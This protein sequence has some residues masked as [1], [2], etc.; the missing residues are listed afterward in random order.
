MNFMQCITKHADKL[1][2][3]AKSK[4]RLLH[5][6]DWFCCFNQI[7]AI[8]FENTNLKLKVLELEL[9]RYWFTF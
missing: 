5:P 7:E 3:C 1:D 2:K 4:V 9:E 8:A 6:F